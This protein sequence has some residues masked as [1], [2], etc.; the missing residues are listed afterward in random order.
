MFFESRQPETA[1]ACSPEYV[2]CRDAFF[3]GDLTRAQELAL[4][5][6]GPR[7]PGDWLLCSDVVRAFG[8]PRGYYAL[9]R[10][11]YRR[12]S[13]DVLIAVQRARS[14]LR[15]DRELLGRLERFEFPDLDDRKRALIEGVL[16]ASRARVGF[17]ER[18]RRHIAAALQLAGEEDPLVNYELA[19]ACSRLGQWDDAIAAGYRV[20]EAAPRWTFARLFLADFLSA[21]G[22]GD[23]ADRLI[24]A[25]VDAGFGDA[26]TGFVRGFRAFAAGEY[27]LAHSRFLEIKARQ[28]RNPAVQEILVHTAWM[29]GDAE[30]AREYARTAGYRL[31]ADLRRRFE[32]GNPQARRCMVP[33]WIMS[34]QT[35][36][37]VAAA[38]SLCAR[39]QGHGL[40]AVEFHALLTDP[41]RRG[42]D[43]ASPWVAVE[44]LRRLGFH[45]M[46]IRARPDI[47]RN[48]LDLGLP[49]VLEHSGVF[50][51]H[52]ETVCGY[53]DGLRIFYVRDPESWVPQTVS[54]ED[55]AT[56]YE[57]GSCGATVLVVPE[58][59]ASVVIPDDWLDEEREALAELA[60]A[61]AGGDVVRAEAAA[62]RIPD[63][64]P[65]ALMR[66][67]YGSGVSIGPRR[68]QEGLRRFAFDELAAP[69]YRVRAHLLL[70][71]EHGEGTYPP[72]ELLQRLERAGERT[73]VRDYVRLMIH[74][75]EG[76][77]ANAAELCIRMLQRAPALEA[78][79]SYLCDA[80]LELGRYEEARA[81]ITEGAEISPAST[82][83][84]SRR[85]LF[86]LAEE[87]VNEDRRILEGLMRE[88]PDQHELRGEYAFVLRRSA[89][90]LEYEDA[91]KAYIRRQPRNPAGYQRLAD[92]YLRQDRKEL[93]EECLEAGRRRLSAEELPDPAGAPDSGDENEKLMNEAFQLLHEDSPQGV[94]VDEIPPIRTLREK[95]N[96]GRLPWQDAVSLH[97]LRLF[98][99]GQDQIAFQSILAEDLSGA[100]PANVE[101]FLERCSGLYWPRP[102]AMALYRWSVEYC[103]RNGVTRARGTLLR[104]HQ[105]RLCE[106]GGE[107]STAETIYRELIEDDPDCAEAHYR[108]GGILARRGA[109]AEARS[110]FERSLEALPGHDEAL[111]ELSDLYLYAGQ[112][113]RALDVQNDLLRLLPYSFAILDRLVLLYR[114]CTPDRFDAVLEHASA[115]HPGESIAGLRV[116][117]ALSRGDAVGA[118]SL[119]DAH[120]RMV[121]L[122]PGVYYR[123]YVS[124][125]LNANDLESARLYIDRGLAALPDDGWLL[126]QRGWFLN[127]EDGDR[128][129]EFYRAAISRGVFDERLLEVYLSLYNASEREALDQLLETVEPALHLRMILW[130]AETLERFEIPHVRADL[131]RDLAEHYEETYRGLAALRYEAA[132]DYLRWN[133]VDEA[134]ALARLM[135]DRDPESPAANALTARCLVLN[136]KFREARSFAERFHARSR[137]AE[138]L[139]LL[140]DILRNENQDDAAGKQYVEALRL[141]SFYGPALIGLVRMGEPSP[142]LP[143]LVFEN[144]RRGYGWEQPWYHVLAVSLAKRHDTA[145]PEEWLAGALKRFDYL[146]EGDARFERERLELAAALRAW[147]RRRRKPQQR[148]FEQIVN[149]AL[150]PVS[151]P[152]EAWVPEEGLSSASL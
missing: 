58:R 13:D 11:A 47:L 74:R 43:G 49:L 106:S 79:W 111:R 14:D 94:G 100:A 67:S 138:S 75:E 124:V 114:R 129:R 78:L 30:K 98:G 97:V 55:F 53:D 104:L 116:Q 3:A 48:C 57:R 87:N 16:A 146:P 117:D 151:D 88:Y 90:G 96:R 9:V 115:V 39:A 76:R 142:E 137:S 64:S 128:A 152:G 5:Q 108:L 145:V 109:G 99:T 66:D 105:G 118:R 33:V 27:K 19:F 119:L 10:L 140:A 83:L 113:D 80:Y 133:R 63:H 77:H 42:Q 4:A 123:S 31:D 122:H 35:G 32:E 121:D 34:Q 62:E 126:L 148:R 22:R 130:L 50:S 1:P 120:P 52:L 26:N 15:F 82:F 70:D 24:D 37:A 101:L 41:A 36:M 110:C 20:V 51:N 91:E 150:R 107:H 103:E 18:A 84:R 69:V 60:S 68:F 59:R 29:Q 135:H 6:D 131:L 65:L 38:F 141:N 56:R 7:I 28:G 127:Q 86:A 92:W 61:C 136:G 85:R 95:Q 112:Y 23:E 89:S 25:I 54:Y 21:C 134:E 81:V 72:P 40:N 149:A 2:A 46:R 45:A 71:A 147:L 125:L 44:E 93:A 73:F 143:G 132:E 8:H 102:T 139:T 144:L 17:R 12:H